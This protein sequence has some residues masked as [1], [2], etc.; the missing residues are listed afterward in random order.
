MKKTTIKASGDYTLT[1]KVNGKEF[2]YSGSSAED[3]SQKLDFKEVPKT[4]VLLSYKKGEKVFNRML[5]IPKF[6]LFLT[7]PLFRTLF[8]K[9]PETMLKNG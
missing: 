5:N 9:I 8:A 3:V 7:R 6:R 2:V 4:K 1:L